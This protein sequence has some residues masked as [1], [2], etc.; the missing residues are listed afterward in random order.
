[1]VVAPVALAT[2]VELIG[3]ISAIGETVERDLLKDPGLHRTMFADGL[4]SAVSAAFG[5]PAQTTYSE[6]TGVLALTRVWD[7][8]VMRIAAIF[9]ILLGFIP[10]ISALMQTIPDAL[11]GGIT[12]ILF[13]FI[14]GTGLRTLMENK[15][16]FGNSRNL[17]IMASIAVLGLGGAALPFTIGSATFQLS[18]LALAAVVGVILN[19]VLPGREK[20]GQPKD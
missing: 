3:D 11:I 12:I 14:A 17:I 4:A 9:A 10:K 2:I 6:N 15:V 19:L 20:S 18:D 8:A 13:G 7:P 1:M 5:G 16:D